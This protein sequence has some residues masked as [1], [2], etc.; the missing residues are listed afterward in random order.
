MLNIT[1]RNLDSSL[2]I[3][4]LAEE[5]L[6][7][8]ARTH[9]E[10]ARAHLVLEDTRGGHAHCDKR[11]AAHLELSFAHHDMSFQSQG[12]SSDAAVAVREAFDHADKQITRTHGRR[13]SQM[14][15]E[16]S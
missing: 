10:S 6:G 12:A 9:G 4:N 2:S 15:S 8:L 11:F 16:R 3:Q 13:S 14:R 1:F 5:L 7:K